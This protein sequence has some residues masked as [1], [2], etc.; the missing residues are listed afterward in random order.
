MKN[1][2]LALIPS[3]CLAL[4]AST[5][6]A[7][8]QIGD[9]VLPVTIT[10]DS[11][12]AFTHNFFTTTTDKFTIAPNGNVTASGGQYTRVAIY[13]P[14]TGGSAPTGSKNAL[15]VF[16]N[17][18]ISTSFSMSEPYSPWIS[19]QTAAATIL[20]IARVQQ[21]GYAIFGT[22]SI[23]RSGPGLIKFGVGLINLTNNSLTYLNASGATMDSFEWPGNATEAPAN[24][25]LKIVMEADGLTFKLSL[26]DTDGEVL[27]TSGW[28]DLS[29]NADLLN[30]HGL[31]SVGGVG[32]RTGWNI[33]VNNT[34]TITEFS[35]TPA[36]PEPA[37]VSMIVTVGAAVGFLAL[38]RRA[39]R[40]A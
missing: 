35:F 20:T 32:F 11:E 36:I 29:S 34:Y 14:G 15:N 9:P 25:P 26:Q 1:Y 21:S 27:V 37:Y 16:Y 17:G 33:P 39:I 5:L 24:T 19:G 7:A 38:R 28:Y 31:D 40:K 13:S 22:T 3:V 23:M 2:T 4:V 8:A 10:F 18:S 12:N 6:P 30:Q